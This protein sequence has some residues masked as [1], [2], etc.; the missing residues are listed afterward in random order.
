MP[1]MKIRAHVVGTVVGILRRDK[2]GQLCAVRLPTPHPQNRRN[3][4]SRACKHARQ[5]TERLAQSET[6]ERRLRSWD[7]W[8]EYHRDEL[9]AVSK[10]LP[11]CCEDLQKRLGTLLECMRQA[12]GDRLFHA[13]SNEALA[14]YEEMDRLRHY[15]RRNAAR[16]IR[17]AQ[18]DAVVAATHG[19]LTN[20]RRPTGNTS[21]ECGAPSV[22]ISFDTMRTGMF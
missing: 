21:P 1:F 14:V 22:R 16:R 4:P 17:E 13:L 20:F 3:L 7:L 15:V 18:A 10:S 6:F 2:R 5:Q 9:D 19:Y 12:R 8:T 11:S